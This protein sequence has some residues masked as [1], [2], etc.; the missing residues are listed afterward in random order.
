MVAINEGGHA[1]GFD[2]AIND[3]D[4]GTGPLKQQLHWS[5]IND[6]F[7]RNTKFFGTLILVNRKELE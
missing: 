6:L 4:A 5:G 2:L 1:I 3:N 7:W